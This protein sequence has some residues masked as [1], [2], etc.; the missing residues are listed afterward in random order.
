VSLT[1]STTVTAAFRVGK[2]RISHLR[3]LSPSLRSKQPISSELGIIPVLSS[4]H[5]SYTGNSVHSSKLRAVFATKSSEDAFELSVSLL[6]SAVVGVALAIVVVTYQPGLLVADAQTEVVNGETSELDENAVLEVLDERVKASKLVEDIVVAEV[7]SRFWPVLLQEWKMLLLAIV[8]TF[9]TSLAELWTMKLGGVV[10]D[11][12]MSKKL[13]SFMGAAWRLCGAVAMQ[14]FLQFIS[15][16]ALTQATE[17]VRARLSEMAFASIIYQD[18]AFFDSHNSAE[19][20]NRLSSDVAEIR[21]VIKQCISLGVKSTTSIVGGMIAAFAKSP[22]L[23]LLVAAAIGSVVSIGSLYARLLRRLSRASKE[24]N[25]RAVICANEATSAVSTV[26]AF[27]GENR[28]I[29]KHAFHLN[30]S[31]VMAQRFGTALGFF[32]GISTAGVSGILVGVLL[33]GGHLVSLGKLSVG[34]LSSFVVVSS[35]IQH[36]LGHIAQL[37]GQVSSGRDAIQRVFTIID[38]K[39]SINPK[40]SIF[41]PPAKLSLS[42]VLSATASVATGEDQK[43]IHGI[44]RL[45][46]VSFAY[47]NRPDMLVLNDVNI[48]LDSGKTLSLV[49]HS[50]SGKSTISRLILRF[51]DPLHGSVT[52]DGIDVR[53]MDPHWLRSQ[54]GIVE[55]EPVLFAGTIW[56]NI[57]YGRP[58]ASHDEIMEASTSANC[59]TFISKFPKGYD[60]VVGERGAQLSGGQKQRI[61]IARALLKNPKILI[62]DEATSALDATTETL[63]QEALNRLMQNRTTLIIAHRLSTI[64]NSDTI[65][66]LDHGKVVEVGSH[67]TLAKAKGFYAKLVKQQLGQSN[68]TA[69]Q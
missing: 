19:L 13:D 61:A 27:V 31:V 4:D 49:G 45:N 59:D 51:Y 36:S 1:S 35:S 66:V 55:Q 33:Y 69:T 48:T 67:D 16:A 9:A 68:A 42:K 8:L 25:A 54:I 60:T 64:K 65:V 21:N 20:M 29:E 11:A 10:I 24:A 7:R 34:D 58:D 15:Y 43:R 6:S 44:V 3:V 46:N 32:K 38:S 39:P 62:L 37:V 52:I 17:R 50:G 23:A 41:G 12:T 22:S 57:A 5:T 56:E 18:K 26:Q 47:A 28:E 63:V 40:T 14:G 30:R 2:G 53:E